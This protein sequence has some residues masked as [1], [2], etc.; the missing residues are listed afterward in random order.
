MPTTL[1]LRRGTT[2]ENAAF[3]GAAGELTVDTTT[4]GLIVH[5]GSTTGGNA[6]VGAGGGGGDPAVTGVMVAN[7]VDTL[8]YGHNVSSLRNCT[9][10]EPVANRIHFAPAWF[11]FET[12]ITELGF[13]TSAADAAATNTRCGIYDQNPTDGYP[14]NLLAGTGHIATASGSGAYTETLGTPLVLAP[15]IYWFAIKTD[16]TVLG[17]STVNV[18]GEGSQGSPVGLNRGALKMRPPYKDGE[19]GAM[20]NPMGTATDILNTSALRTAGFL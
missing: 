4:N 6:V 19:T 16:S 11:F 20:P 10:V 17:V 8:H 3:T 12:T 7:Q 2:A 15:G 13:A 1:Q 18:G 14:N 5:D 9:Q